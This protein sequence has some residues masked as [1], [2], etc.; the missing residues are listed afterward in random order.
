MINKF[1]YSFGLAFMISAL[2]MVV[3]YIPIKIK[4]MEYLDDRKKRIK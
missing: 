4:I 2:I 1:L 3:I